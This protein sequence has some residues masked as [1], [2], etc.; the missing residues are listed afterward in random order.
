MPSDEALRVLQAIPDGH[1][2]A[3]SAAGWCR[4][5][6][7]HPALLELRTDA[8]ENALAVLWVLARYTDHRTKLT[9]PTW[10]RLQA[11]TGLS[12]AAV[13]RWLRWARVHRLIGHVEQ[14]STE[15]Y[16]TGQ[17]AEDLGNRSAVYILLSETPSPDPT[18]LPN[19]TRAREPELSTKLAALRAAGGDLDRAKTGGERLAAAELLK[20][21]V[22]PARRLSAR[23]V[24]SLCREFFKAGWCVRDLHYALDNEPNGTPHPY[25]YSTSELR[26]PAGWIAARL[27]H[28][29]D[30]A[31]RPIPGRRQLLQA[32]ADAARVARAPRAQHKP[33]EEPPRPPAAVSQ[34]ATLVRDR[35]V[36]ARAR[37]A[38]ERAERDRI[39]AWQSA[40]LPV[41]DPQRRRS[42]IRRRAL[43]RAA[44]ERNSSQITP[45]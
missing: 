5:V 16:R 41:E 38:R 45:S 6:E 8:R 4:A 21:R 34:L 11:V 26:S 32:Q 31:G 40:P 24:R 35:E 30:S 3:G 22:P 39:E 10:A 23:H 42:E 15:R 33:Q 29:R 37:A 18:S 9:R 25:A 2:R 44:L 7:R 13:A 17:T 36:R 19:P 27:A 12:R 20:Q 14:G 43:A 1:Q 28:W